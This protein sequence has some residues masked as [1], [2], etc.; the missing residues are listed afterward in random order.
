MTVKFP[1]NFDLIHF[2]EIFEEKYKIWEGGQVK[3]SWRLYAHLE[4]ASKMFSSYSLLHNIYNPLTIAMN[5][6]DKCPEA[7]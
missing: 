3:R 2:V 7:V 4:H 6:H 5:A 1:I